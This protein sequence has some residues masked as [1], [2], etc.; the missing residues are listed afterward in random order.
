MVSRSLWRSAIV[1]GIN[2]SEV[3]MRNKVALVGAVALI[4]LVGFGG[5]MLAAQKAAAPENRSKSD[6]TTEQTQTSNSTPTETT[7]AALTI[8]YTDNGFE[9][10]SYTIQKGQ[11]VKVINQSSHSLEFA[12]ADHPTHKLNPELNLTPINAGQS[13]T[14]SPTKVGT[15]GIHDHFSANMTTTLVVTE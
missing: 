10:S 15:W 1:I 5:W 2:E 3:E 11:T 4:L 9:K 12:S 13:T 14:F 8:V 7:T 6:T